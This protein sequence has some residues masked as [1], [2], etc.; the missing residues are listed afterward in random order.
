L[1][2]GRTDD[3]QEG[4]LV[5][6]VIPRMQDDNLQGLM[7]Q[8]KQPNYDLDGVAKKI[9]DKMWNVKFEEEEQKEKKEEVNEVSEKNEPTLLRF[10]SGSNEIEEAIKRMQG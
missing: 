6:H 1:K 4:K 2:S 3:N 7:W 8:P 10:K 9:K 5:L